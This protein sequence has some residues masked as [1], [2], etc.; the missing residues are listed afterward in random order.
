MTSLALL[1]SLACVIIMASSLWACLS[2]NVFDGFIL[3]ICLGIATLTAYIEL[4]H[5]SE[6]ALDVL[7]I[8]IAGICVAA[9]FQRYVLRRRLFHRPGEKIGQRHARSA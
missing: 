1:T 2:H 3:K 4:T 6:R 5:P 8:S 7:V 9:T